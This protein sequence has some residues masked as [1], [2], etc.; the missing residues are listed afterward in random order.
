[1]I[2]CENLA[3]GYGGKI[4]FQNLSF[5]INDGDYLCII[6]DNGT[7]KTTLVKTLL[8]LK[9]PLSGKVIMPQGIG[10]LPQQTELQKDFPASVREVVL[11]GCLGRMGWKAFYSTDDKARADKAMSMMNILDLS[12]KCYRDFREVSRKECY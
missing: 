10:Y 4:I 1:M 7:G 12:S 3:L 2:A 5:T 11:S 9:L 8:G 6:G